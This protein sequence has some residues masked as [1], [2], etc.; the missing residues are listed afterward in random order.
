MLLSMRTWVRGCCA[1]C[2][3]LAYRLIH[4]KIGTK[5]HCKARGG[6]RALTWRSFA[7]WIFNV[8]A[9]WSNPSVPI[10]YR[11][12]SP[13]IVLRFSSWHF[14][15]ASDVMKEMNSD[16]HSCTHSFASFAILAVGGTEAFII[17]ET[18]AIWSYS[19]KCLLWR[20]KHWDSQEESGPVL[21][22]PLPPAQ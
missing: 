18:L 12:S 15:A 3:T 6:R 4:V 20:D 10:A 8:S 17:R 7:R 11:I 5:I 22:I 19:F 2:T 14:S 16:T 1:I 13:P 21:C 9:Y